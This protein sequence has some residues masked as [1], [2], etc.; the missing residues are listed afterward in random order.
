MQSRHSLVF[1]KVGMKNLPGLQA[2]CLRGFI[3]DSDCLKLL[4][5]F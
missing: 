5:G 3:L 1:D 4:T 2:I